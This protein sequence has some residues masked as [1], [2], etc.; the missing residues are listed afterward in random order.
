MQA[1]MHAYIHTY[2]HTY[3]HTYLPI[4][5]PT[6]L[7]TYIHGGGFFLRLRGFGETVRQFI[8]PPPS[9]QRYFF[10]KVEISSRTLIPLFMPE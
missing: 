10:F 8:P 5:T 7:P 1:C 3:K 2:I 9:R 4:Y 6:Y